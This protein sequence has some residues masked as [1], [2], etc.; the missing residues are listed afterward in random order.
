[1]GS[2]SNL[3]A[4]RQSHERSKWVYIYG[5]LAERD[6]LTNEILRPQLIDCKGAG[7][8]D[9]T[10]GLPKMYERVRVNWTSKNE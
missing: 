1:M 3:N 6:G 7:V 9:P 2:R 5:W 10:M 4:L 8:A